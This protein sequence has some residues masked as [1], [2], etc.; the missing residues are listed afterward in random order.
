MRKKALVWIF[1]LCLNVLL[2]PSVLQAQRKAAKAEKTPSS[3]L[4]EKARL[5]NTALFVDAVKERLLEN[6]DV[7]ESMLHRVLAVEPDHDAAHYELAVILTLKGRVQEA[8]QEVK[9]AERCDPENMWYK[10]MLG[11]LYNQTQ[12]P[13]KAAPYWKFLAQRQP[14]NLEYLNNYAYALLQQEKLKEAVEVY[15]LMQRQLGLN[16]QL[17][18]TKK[19][20]W[21]YLNKPDKAVA[22][23]DAL[24]A[25]YPAEP[26]YLVEAAQI[27]MSAHKEAKAVPY[28]EKAQQLDSNNGT[29]LMMLYDYYAG[30]RKEKEAD[31]CMDRIMRNA[32]VSLETKMNALDEFYRQASTSRDTTVFN[33][34]YRWLDL[35]IQ[36]HPQAAGLF[37]AR[38]YL[39]LMQ[40]RGAEAIPDLEASLQRD[41][42]Q[43]N[44]W[45]MYMLMLLE[46]DQ[47]ARAAAAGEEAVRLFPTQALPYYAMACGAMDERDFDRAVS[48]LETAC[49]YAEDQP[50]LLADIYRL[51]AI[52]YEEQG[53]F[54]KA[55]EARERQRGF[56]QQLR[57]K[58]KHK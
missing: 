19:T 12:Q 17:S 53:Q 11:D 14:D 30:H 49:R 34:V 33:R 2:A 58:P 56:Q 25:A 24:I 36:T 35:A 21:L 42:S 43:Y 57:N 28:L 3:V 37:S 44:T 39:R 51:M 54:S 45:K 6:Y 48:E 20:V 5:A 18:E 23:L 1:V 50:A 40:G 46:T 22:E 13:E 7:A 10:V 15:E 55:E 16:E 4:P 41:S 47:P 38:A 9:T 52:V 8:I 29:L 27:Y 32:G 31:A 26:N